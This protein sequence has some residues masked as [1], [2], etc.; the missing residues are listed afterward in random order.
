VAGELEQAIATAYTALGD[1]WFEGMH[2]RTD[3][4]RRRRD[5]GQ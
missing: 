5:G 4:G 1:I 2:Y 3:I